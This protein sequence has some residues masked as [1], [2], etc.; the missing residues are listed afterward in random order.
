MPPP[1]QT[2]EQ[3]CVG[4]ATR[5]EVWA[6][7]RDEQLYIPLLPFLEHPYP[8]VAARLIDG[9]AAAGIP[10]AE[11][12]LMPLRGLVVFALAGPMRWGW[13]G[14]AVSWIEAGFPVDDEIASALEGMTQDKRFPQRV[15]HG[16]F[17]A[18]R[19][20]RR[21]RADPAHA[22]VL[23]NRPRHKPRLV[24]LP[25]LDGTGRLLRDFR[26]A[27]GPHARTILVSYPADQPLDYTALEAIVRSRLPT[28][29]PFVLL[30][31]SFSGP[32][33]IS[34]AANRPAGLRGLILACS[35]ARNPIPMLAPLG[36]SIRLLPIRWAPVALLAWT[37]LGRYA[38]PTLRSELADALRRVSPSVIRKRLRLVV[39]VDVSPLLARVAV[40]IL[41]LRASEDRLVPRS[42]SYALAAMPHVRF[43]EIEGPHFL[44]QAN[45]STAAAYVQEFLRE[46]EIV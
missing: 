8:I 22:G 7:I 37:T 9:L 5:P 13:G 43:V 28:R 38:T 6:K 23:R 32:I 35:F 10:R 20:W 25:G 4:L 46:V 15:R 27:I 17:A 1:Y 26:R 16:A 24:I 18:A 14:Y 34:I 21:A 40:P 12:E 45:P 30:A 29:K 11:A 36:P 3:I 19:G 2:F 39:D 44:L 33:A 42:G 41:Y 31:E